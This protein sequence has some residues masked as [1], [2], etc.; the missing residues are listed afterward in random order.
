[1]DEIKVKAPVVFDSSDDSDESESDNDDR[2]TTNELS[3]PEFMG[4]QAEDSDNEEDTKKTRKQLQF[5]LR[6][7]FKK[8]ARRCKPN[9]FLDDRCPK[10]EEIDDFGLD[11]IV[12]SQ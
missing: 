4:N 12:Q 10:E 6:K 2:V 3:M 8:Q 5:E 1:M 7:E 9:I 11:S